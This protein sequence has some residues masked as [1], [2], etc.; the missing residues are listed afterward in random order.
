MDR[1][2][3]SNDFHRLDQRSSP[4]D[5]E[6]FMD[7]FVMALLPSIAETIV[8]LQYRSS[9]KNLFLLV[10]H[11]AFATQFAVVCGYSDFV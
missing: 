5:L 11:R 3:G 6:A 9:K 8:C 2:D 7:T 1:G 4:A 10:P